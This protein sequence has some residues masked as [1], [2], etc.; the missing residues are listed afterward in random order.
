MQI[1]TSGK[2]LIVGGAYVPPHSDNSTYRRLAESCSEISGVI[3]DDGDALLCCDV[4]LP[5]IHC[6]PHDEIPTVFLPTYTRSGNDLIISEALL[7][8]GWFQLNGQPNSFG[9][10]LE[11]IFC[12]RHDD[13]EINCPAP[14]LCDDFGSSNAHHPVSLTYAGFRVTHINDCG[15]RTQF[16]FAKADYPRIMEHFQRVDWNLVLGSGDVNSKVSKFY[17]FLNECLPMFIPTRS[18]HR[19]HGRTCP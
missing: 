17:G 8:H 12:S 13:I 5:G 16:D 1:S 4:N 19:R 11:T 15:S 10:L 18:Q 9:N 14:A 3:G 7:Q 2:K 6:Q